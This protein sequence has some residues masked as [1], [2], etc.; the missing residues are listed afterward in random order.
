MVGRH[1]G[2]FFLRLPQLRQERQYPCLPFSVF[3]CVCWLPFLLC[4]RSLLPGQ[5]PTKTT[6]RNL[7]TARKKTR[8]T[9][10]E[11]TLFTFSMTWWIQVGV[12][13]LPTRAS[14]ATRPFTTPRNEGRIA[15]EKQANSS[16]SLPHTFGLF[17]RLDLAMIELLFRR[18]LL[19]SQENAWFSLMLIKV[20]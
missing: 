1:L 5:R 12:V 11:A 3:C 2:F 7:R 4:T 15:F 10:S 6:R 13:D 14:P 20:V 19:D 17:I 18:L 16:H 8:R 9:V